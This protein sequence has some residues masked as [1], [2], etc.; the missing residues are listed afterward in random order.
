MLC[1][2]VSSVH[3]ARLVGHVPAAQH[4]WNLLQAMRSSEASGPL[5]H[6][7]TTE[8]GHELLRLL[9]RWVRFG[10]Q[11]NLQDHRGR[12]LP[13]LMPTK[14]ILLTSRAWPH[15]LMVI[16][17]RWHSSREAHPASPGLTSQHPSA[18]LADAASTLPAASLRLAKWQSLCRSLEQVPIVLACEDLQVRGLPLPAPAGPQGRVAALPAGSVP[19]GLPSCHATSVTGTTPRLAG[20]PRLKSLI[21]FPRN[22]SGFMTLGLSA[23]R[24]N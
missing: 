12:P 8:R 4:G 19:S 6:E 2:S 7:P 23:F 24:P 20:W 3:G 14:P 21:I 5:R 1:Q 16:C 10:G 22:G 17:I 13:R 9:T 11:M 15:A 18:S